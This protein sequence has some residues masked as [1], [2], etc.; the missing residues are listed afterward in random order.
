MKK[1][2]L[3][4][5]LLGAAIYSPAQITFQKTFGGT[6]VDRFFSVQ[7]TTDGGYIMAGITSSFGSD[8]SNV[9]LIKTD[10]Y[11]DTIWTKTFG[12]ND[13][14]AG[15]FVR[16]TADGGYIITGYTSSFGAGNDDIYLIKTDINGNALWSKTFGGLSF[17]IS[18]SVHQTTDGGYIIGGTAASNFAI[19][20]DYYIIKTDV[21]GD[22]LWTKTLGSPDFD[23]LYAMQQT[24]DGGYI[25]TGIYYDTT[26]FNDKVLLIKTDSNGGTLWTK[27]YGGSIENFPAY[28]E[29]TT[30]GGYIISGII[31]GFGAGD[32]DALLIKTDSIGTAQWFKAYGGTD[33]EYGLF[34]HQTADGGYL[35]SG[36]TRSFGAGDE[37]DYLVKTDASGN[38]L[39]TKTFGG[40]SSDYVYC[41]QQTA[42]GGYILAGW[43]DSFGSGSADGFLIKTDANGNSGCNEAG[44]STILTTGI[45]QDAS[46]PV[47]VSSGGIVGAPATITGSGG[48]VS[49]LCISVGIN[50]ITSDN[51]FLISPNPSAGYFTISFEEKIKGTI[52][53]SNTLGE[54]VYA[55]NIFN[56]STKEFKLNNIPGGIY[57][58]K[59]FVYSDS[60]GNGE[61]HYCRKIIVEQ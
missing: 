45:G 32:L 18:Y 5:F 6:N 38:L 39:W 4:L 43:T 25:I 47:V 51:S 19:N 59:V 36:I 58:V 34:V 1:Q 7:Q 54:N 30:D 2:L 27:T 13:H 52:E 16:Q 3:I 61:K 21:N 37:D 29:Q 15:Y 53:I 22:S 26:T 41:S 28:V 40:T 57:F 10:A 55:E 14:D 60:T 46:V 23:D 20:G 9:Y 56:E 12:G 50:E 24:T 17:D 33:V 42:D 48:M 35:M 49:T 11:G 44:T 8:S 31:Y